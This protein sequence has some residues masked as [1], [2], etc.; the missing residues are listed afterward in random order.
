MRLKISQRGWWIT[1]ATIFPE[2]AMERSAE[3]TC[4]AAAESRPD[5]GSSSISSSGSLT[6]SMPI[7]QRFSS[8]PE[9]PRTLESPTTESPTCA[10]PSRSSTRAT[11]ARLDSL[12]TWS[13][14]RICAACISRSRTVSM[15]SIESACNTRHRHTS[16]EQRR[17]RQKIKKS[18]N[19]KK[20]SFACIA[21][22]L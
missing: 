22:M 8:P 20:M 9:M 13:G 17:Q 19:K 1:A 18:K 16:M 11:R 21:V 14:R 15:G 4:M 10:M 3:Q 7:E 2:A 6:S 12:D 5:V